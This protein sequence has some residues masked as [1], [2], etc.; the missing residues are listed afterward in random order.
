MSDFEYKVI[1]APSVAKKVKGAKTLAE[2]FAHG[3]SE[4]INAEAR[5]GW[6]YVAQERFQVEGK[7][8]LLGKSRTAEETFLIFRRAKDAKS[9]VPLDQR[10]ETMVE[11]RAR[12]KPVEK[13]ATQSEPIETVVPVPAPNQPKPERAE[14]RM[15]AD[16][17]APR[18][19]ST[20]GIF[21]P[22]SSR[23]DDG[24]DTA[25]ENGPKIGP[26]GRD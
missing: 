15:L 18:T 1:V 6:D 20:S 3:L 26:A 12:N 10:L 22:L 23:D 19:A 5:E 21:S 8:G 14:P 9:A 4:V 2:R 24:A 25:P 17:E 7:S 11:K 13:P 16:P